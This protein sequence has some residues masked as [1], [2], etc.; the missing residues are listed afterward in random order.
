M[1]KINTNTYKYYIVYLFLWFLHGIYILTL[2]NFD[3]IKI[4]IWMQKFHNIYLDIILQYITYLGNVYIFIFGLL[5]VYHN[6][7]YFYSM[8]LSGAISVITVLIM[9]NYIFINNYRPIILINNNEL[10]YHLIN[11]KYDNSFPSGHSVIAFSFWNIVNLILIDKKINIT[12]LI[13]IIA[14]IISYSRVYLSHHFFID[15]YIGSLIGIIIS[16]VSW[17][18]INTILIKNTQN[19]I[20][21]DT[22]KICYWFLRPTRLPVSPPGHRKLKKI[23]NN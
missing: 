2:F 4:H 21:T 20:R 8:L 12:I 3:K 19:R 17:L 1:F 9:K 14:S 15:I 7:K 23:I 6:Y 16:I 11:V 22:T 10:L 18:L 13:L 5:I